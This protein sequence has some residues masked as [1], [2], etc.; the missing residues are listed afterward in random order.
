MKTQSNGSDERFGQGNTYN[1][2]VRKILLGCGIL[3]SLLY[4]AAGIM[5]A[6]IWE[7]YDPFSQCVSELFATGAPSKPFID[8]LLFAFSLIWIA[9]GVGVWMSANGKWVLRIAAVGLMIKEIEGLI[10]QLFFPMSMRG[11]ETTSNDTLHG[12][13][14]LIGVLAFLSAM[15]FGS[16]AFGKRFRLYSL[17]TLVIS[18]FFSALTGIYVPAVAANQPTPWMGVWERIGIFSYLLWAVV[19]AA[20]LLRVQ[21]GSLKSEDRKTNAHSEALTNHV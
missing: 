19:L 14:T 13:L 21:T 16:A 9:F 8:P 1:H 2:M 12:V 10:V 4:V 3:A 15:A 7:G 18:F 11:V 6:M 17:G 20:G 5:G